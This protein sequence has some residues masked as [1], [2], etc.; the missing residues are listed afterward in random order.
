MEEK[1]QNGGMSLYIES[2]SLVKFLPNF[3]T[4]LI[5]SVAQPSTTSVARRWP[6]TRLR[7]GVAAA[8]VTHQ[9][10]T[11]TLFYIIYVLGGRLGMIEGCRR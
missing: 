10:G 4:I 11:E 9:P 8:Q 1:G 5:K 2:G 7:L 3:P 6:R